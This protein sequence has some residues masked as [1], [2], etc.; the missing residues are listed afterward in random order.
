MAAKPTYEELK[1]KV[2]KLEQVLLEREHVGKELLLKENIIMSSSSVIATCDLEGKMTYG[3]PAF[4][5]IW[6]FDDAKEFLGRGTTMF[7]SL[8]AWCLMRAV[9]LKWA[10]GKEKLW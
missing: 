6:G 4:L 3:N 1:Q 5:E 9:F 7:S 8:A 2:A 10:Q